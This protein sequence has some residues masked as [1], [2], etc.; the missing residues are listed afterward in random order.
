MVFF[1]WKVLDSLCYP[2]CLARPHS[3]KFVRYKV[4]ENVHEDFIERFD[5]FVRTYNIF[6]MLVPV[7]QVNAALNRLDIGLIIVPNPT[8]VGGRCQVRDR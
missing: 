3:F 8:L 1:P 4:R 6:K 5:L 2:G 7:K